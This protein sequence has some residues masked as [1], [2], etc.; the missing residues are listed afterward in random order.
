M[1]S[2]RLEDRK[3]DMDVYFMR[4]TMPPMISNRSFFATHMQL[5]HEDGTLTVVVTSKGNE[6]YQ[7]KNAND[8]YWDVQAL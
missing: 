1:V 6:E 7:V 3:D 8:I 4:M 2:V 5:E